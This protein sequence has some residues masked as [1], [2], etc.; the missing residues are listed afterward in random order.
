MGAECLR[1]GGIHGMEE[2]DVSPTNIAQCLGG[3]NFPCSSD[4]LV[5]Y[6]E[7]HDCSPEALD[8]LYSLPEKEYRS[9][10]DVMS[11]IGDVE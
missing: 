1:K 9:I 10:A 6:A 5:E 4:D 8:V 2:R 11:G 7:T 3:I